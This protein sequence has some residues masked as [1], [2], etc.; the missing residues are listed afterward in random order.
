M[1]IEASKDLVGKEIVINHGGC[2]YTYGRIIGYGQNKW[3]NY[4]VVLK[5]EGVEEMHNRFD[6][7]EKRIGIKVLLD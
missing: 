7:N 3:G 1:T 5:E 2:I 4:N 6:T